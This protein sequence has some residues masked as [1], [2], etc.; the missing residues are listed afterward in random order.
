M[1]RPSRFESFRYLG[2][3]R[4]QIVYDLDL[5]EEAGL[6]PVI[7]ELLQSEAFAAFAPDTLAEARNRGY[8]ASRSIREEGDRTADS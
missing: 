8:R 6:Q 7:H 4:T 3:K 2:D 5:V 1:S